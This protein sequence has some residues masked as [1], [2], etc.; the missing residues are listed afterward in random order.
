MVDL[1]PTDQGILYLLQ[2]DARNNTTAG[3]GERVGVSSTTVGNRINKLEEKD[4]ITAY[5][6]ILNY[7][8]A[9]LDHHMLVTATAPMDSRS[10][11]AEDALEVHGVVAVR[12]LLT[13][14][15]NLELEIATST[16]QELEESIEALAELGLDLVRNELL[17]RELHKPA[18]NFGRTLSTTIVE[19]ETIYTSKGAPGALRVRQCVQCLQ[20]EQAECLGA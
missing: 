16:R 12:E 14:H 7:E 18:D 3:I 5:Q 17:K 20:P 4:I 10:Q 8:K 15:R 1:D 6:P 19:I 13:H 2:Q 9:G 11:L